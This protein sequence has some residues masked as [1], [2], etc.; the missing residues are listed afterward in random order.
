MKTRQFIQLIAVGLLLLTACGGG[1]SP[2]ID[3]TRAWFQALA[4]LRFDDVLKLTCASEP[5]RNEI[6]AKLD[7]FIDLKPTLDALKGQFDFSNLKFE[8][9]SNNGRVATIRLSGSMTL[10]ALGQTEAMD[11][12]ED[13]TVI[14]E[15]GVWKVCA[16]PL[17]SP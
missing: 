7:P 10:V 15:N 17:K 11:V 1:G 3:G 12:A 6:A 16:N 2:A 14:N 8:E 9:K 5:V 4:E 13:L